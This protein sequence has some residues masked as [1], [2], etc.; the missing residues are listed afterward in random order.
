MYFSCFIAMLTI[1]VNIAN[2]SGA[3]DEHHERQRNFHLVFLTSRTSA[4]LER[5]LPLEDFLLVSQSNQRIPALENGRANVNTESRFFIFQY[6]SHREYDCI[7][8]PVTIN[9]SYCRGTDVNC[10]T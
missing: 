4:L 9:E 1:I 8:V 2:D 3:I 6:S 10:V 5:F 7:V